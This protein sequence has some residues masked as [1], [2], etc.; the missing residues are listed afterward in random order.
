[1][2]APGPVDHVVGLELHDAAPPAADV[3]F[4][5]VLKAP[6]RSSSGGLSLTTVTGGVGSADLRLGEAQY[7]RVSK[8]RPVRSPRPC[9]RAQLLS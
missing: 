6:Y 3:P 4:D 7:Y 1:V 9:S 8:V 5:D 2:Q